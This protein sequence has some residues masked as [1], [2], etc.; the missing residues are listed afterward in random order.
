VTV[1]R[2]DLIP[3]GTKSRFLI[4]YFNRSSAGEFVYATPPEGGAQVALAICAYQ[5]GKQV[6]LFVPAR[7]VRT[8]YTMRAADFGARII[9]IR[10]GY[11]NVVQSKAREYAEKRGAFLMPFGLDLDIAVESIAAAAD[12]LRILPDQVWCA[13]GSGVLARSLALAW[14]GV[15]IRAVQVG[16]ANPIATYSAAEPFQKPATVSVPFPSHPYYDAKAWGVCLM[17]RIKG[18]VLF[19][20]VAA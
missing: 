6:T 9:E 10:P 15:D 11:L 19:W 2:D 4:E 17:H 16:K 18:N 5:A 1:V 8:S 3:G 13:C 7:R 12:S 14:P 20:N